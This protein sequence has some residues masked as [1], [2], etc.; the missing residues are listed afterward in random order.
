MGYGVLALCQQQPPGSPPSSL[1]PSSLIRVPGPPPMLGAS[2][3]DHT[4]AGGWG[5]C[6]TCQRRPRVPAS[7]CPQPLTLF[8][9]LTARPS[10]PSLRTRSVCYTGM[11]WPVSPGMQGGS[12]AGGG[13][14]R[15]PPFPAPAGALSALAEVD[16]VQASGRA[17]PALNS[18]PTGCLP[19]SPGG[20]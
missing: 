1:H 9:G 6:S 11:S 14:C 13:G 10:C 12:P 4:L 8:A 15:S 7:L 19:A 3:K 17:A 18:S 20:R 2:R 16:P 5:L